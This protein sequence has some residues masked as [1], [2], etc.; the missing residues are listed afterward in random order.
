M[1]DGYIA[2]QGE[3]FETERSSR[4]GRRT[5]YEEVEMIFLGVNY[6]F[7]FLE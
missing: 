7:I 4:Y 2:G 3:S 6:F 5:G 1:F